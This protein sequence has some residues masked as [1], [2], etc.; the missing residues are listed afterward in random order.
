MTTLGPVPASYAATRD[1]LHRLAVYVVSPWR[2]ARTSRI[3]LRA[4]PGGFGTPMTGADDERLRVGP[5]GLS[6]DG[7]RPVAHAV[8]TLRAAARALDVT[9]DPGRSERFDVPPIGDVDADLAVDPASV[10]FLGSWFALGDALLQQIC[11]EAPPLEEP[12]EIQLW[13][14]HFDIATEIGAGPART[15]Y[16]ASPG[17][18]AHPLPYLYAVPWTAP[19]GGDVFWNEPHFRGRSL[20]YTELRD[21]SDPHVRAAEFL[22]E[23]RARVAADH[24]GTS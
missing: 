6:I 10:A 2:E 18:A 13:P 14:E 3:G 1:A 7:P 20:G 11:A 24:G 9:L 19:P 15:G 12:S 17:D 16:G 5:D 4:V 23:C 22:A 21:A 8:T